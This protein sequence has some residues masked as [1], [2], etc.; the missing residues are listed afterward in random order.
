MFCR[1]FKRHSGLAQA[2]FN[3]ARLYTAGEGVRRDYKQALYW[4]RKAAAQDYSP[5]KNRLGVIYE[6]GEGVPKDLIEA[7]KWYTLAA[8][9]NNISAIANR[10]HL[11]PRLTARQ[12]TEAKSR[13]AAISL[14]D[15]SKAK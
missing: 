11:A 6:R 1:L 5:A 12:I 2:Q 10:D 4:L 7:Y 8:E 9:A 3:L 13:A 15:F 14:A